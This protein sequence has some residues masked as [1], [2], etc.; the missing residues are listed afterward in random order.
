MAGFVEDADPKAIAT[1]VEP[2]F[3][4]DTKNFEE[5]DFFMPDGEDVSWSIAEAIGS[6]ARLMGIPCVIQSSYVERPNVL[7]PLGPAIWVLKLTVKL[8]FHLRKRVVEE[9]M[10]MRSEPRLVTVSWKGQE[11]L[12]KALAQSK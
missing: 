12:V 7:D 1:E 9:E 4:Y 5:I 3:V 10:E 11:E 2:I 6:M 8:P